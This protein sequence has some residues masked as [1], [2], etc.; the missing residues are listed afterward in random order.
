MNKRLL[1][2]TSLLLIAV[3]PAFAQSNLYT[4]RNG[5]IE[6][7]TGTIDGEPVSLTTTYIGNN[8]T[9]TGL[10]GNSF[11][12]TNGTRIGNNTTTTGLIG[13][14]FVSTNSTRIGNNTSTTGLIG[15][16]N[17]RPNRISQARAII[18]DD[19]ESTYNFT[20]LLSP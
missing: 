15:N 19:E 6:T 1:A 16:S 17:T 4:T 3:V 10:I 9:T 20:T 12:S 18:D 5:N 11:V 7:T 2:W 14:S 8:T 13:N